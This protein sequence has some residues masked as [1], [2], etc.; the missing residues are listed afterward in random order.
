MKNDESY[1]SG[2]PHDDWIA[3]RDIVFPFLHADDPGT[4]PMPPV[5]ENLQHHPVV[6]AIVRY[7]KNGKD[8]DLDLAGQ[9]LIPTDEPFGWYVPLTK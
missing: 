5:P 3:L 2:I 1:G 7:R 6:K 9:G 8:E 4:V